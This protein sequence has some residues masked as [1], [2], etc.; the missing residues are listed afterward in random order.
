[1]AKLVFR[2]NQVP[3]AEADA[4]RQLLTDN[5]IDF[6]ETQEG[7]WGL[8]VAAL[9]LKQDDDFAQARALIDEFQQEH[10]LAMRDEY[11]Q[12]KRDGKIP[13]FWQLLRSN[14]VLF[15]S[16]WVLILAVLLL[17]LVPMFQFFRD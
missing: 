3:E 10:S 6:Y 1:M 8:S 12:A 15:V 9:W 7:R 17:T 14:P 4:V 2:L 5:E 16:Y 13:T 11:E